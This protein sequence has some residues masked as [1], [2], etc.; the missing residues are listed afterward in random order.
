MKINIIGSHIN[1][2]KAYGTTVVIDVLR[3]FTTACYILDQKV[4]SLI[5][6]SDTQSARKI[7]QNNPNVILVGEI[8]GIK[9]DGF[10]FGNSPFQISQANLTDKTIVFTTSSGTKGILNSIN[11]DEIITGAFVNCSA[12]VSYLKNKKISSVSLIC[13]DDRYKDNEDYLCALYIS[14][15]L[16][17]KTV[18]FKNLVEKIRKHPTSDGFLRKPITK[19]SRSDFELA[20]QFNKFN[21][22]I[23][24]NKKPNNLKL[25]RID[26][27]E[28]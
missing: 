13:T 15:S 20:M 14:E 12:I 23:K 24:A 10:N 6:V 5:V 28:K 2:H 9:P 26:V 1:A 27:Y 3:A 25:E 16:S 8:K 17:G 22:V 7:K 4:K 11:A 19:F 18:N 21:F